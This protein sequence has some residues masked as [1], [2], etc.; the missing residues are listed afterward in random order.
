MKTVDRRDFLFLL[1]LMIVC[2]LAFYRFPLLQAD[3]HLSVISE[4][5]QT[6][7]WPTPDG[8]KLRMAHHPLAHHSL[9]ALTWKAP[10]LIGLGPVY[11]P[12]SAQVLSLLYALGT[13][14]LVARIV[15][16]LVPVPEARRMAYL[17]FG[18]FTGFVISA[19][20]V[21]ND[22][23]MAFWGT[24]ALLGAV[25]IM[26][27][28]RPP[29]YW[30]IAVLGIVLGLALLMKVSALAMLSATVFCLISRRWYYGDG[31]VDIGK[32]VVVITMIC[33][34]FYLPSVWRFPETLGAN[35]NEAH[36]VTG[37]LSIHNRSLMADMFILPLAEL[38]KRPFQVTP[39]VCYVNRADYSFWTGIFISNWS[40]PS[41]LPDPPNPYITVLF[42][43]TAL[44]VALCICCGGAIAVRGAFFR[45]E[46][47]VVLIWILIFAAVWVVANLFGG[48]PVADVRYILFSIGSQI[49]FL[50]LFYQF[51]L[52]RLPRF[53]KVFWL[54]ICS[55]MLLFLLMAI[56]GPFY[57][58][59]S[60][61][62]NLHPP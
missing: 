48:F 45:P 16:H 11:W 12:E 7:R 47:F 3:D 36:H 27:D 34:I 42:F 18:T 53:R 54:I 31:W 19:V 4:I 59:H 57:Y 33:L 38:M 26:R 8:T 43:L 39:G 51:V 23:A 35:P 29:S 62:P 30:R 14:L 15:G 5:Y 24:A 25:K 17:V 6:G 44:F 50:A 20:S 61:W 21:S 60:T 22:M 58:F 1:P 46:L 32:R 40:L 41:H 55:H 9:A 2:V 56:N 52:R 37:G 10:E 49:T 28:S 13:V